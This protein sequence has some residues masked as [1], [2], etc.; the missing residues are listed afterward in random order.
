M[1][2]FILEVLTP[3]KTLFWGRA[4]AL[5]AHAIDGEVQV[6][7]GHAPYINI[8]AAGEIRL[9]NE[10]NVCLHFKHNGGI[11]EVARKKTS[12]LVQACSEEEIK[13]N[14]NT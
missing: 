13:A 10:D 7:P 1:K 12:V 9:H 14:L 6:L 3:D 11:L 5:T 2:D 4:T 8:L